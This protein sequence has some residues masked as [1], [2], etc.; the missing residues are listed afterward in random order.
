MQNKNYVY[1][2]D[3]GAVG[4]GVHDDWE[5]IR[6]AHN[7]ANERRTEGYSVKAKAGAT[8]LIRDITKPTFIMTD[9]DWTGAKFI[10]DDTDLVKDDLRRGRIF[11][12]APEEPRRA[13]TEEEI[14]E[15][16]PESKIDKNNFTSVKW[17]YGFPALLF[18]Y[19]EKHKNYRRMGRDGLPTGGGSQL[20]LISVDKD[21]NV[22]DTTPL[23]CDYEEITALHIIRCDDMPITLHGGRFT[24]IK[25]DTVFTAGIGTYLER[26]I[27]SKRSNITY[28]GVEHY[29]RENPDDG[30]KYPA[31]SGFIFLE[32]SNNV[33]LIG[34]TL[35]GHRKYFDG[36]YDFQCYRANDILLYKC[37]QSNF[38]L[39]DGKTP[40][41]H[42]NLYWGIMG[43]SYCKNITFDSCTMSRYDAHAGIYNGK[44]TNCTMNGI[45]IIGGGDFL[46]ENSKLVLSRNILIDL[47]TDYGSTWRGNITIRNCEVVNFKP[48]STHVF[49]AHW[50]NWPFGYECH[51]PN[52]LIDGLKF[53]TV[54]GEIR[55][56]R[57]S[58]KNNGIDSIDDTISEKTLRDGTEN[59]N[60]YIP[61]DSIVIKNSD[62][63]Y[64]LPK[65]SYFDKTKTE[66]VRRT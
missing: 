59:K 66:G 36:T 37:V 40:S 30:N 12:V 45:E 58:A 42:N 33:K 39:E 49:S 22:S 8:Y 1:Y 15:I 56:Y 16:F 17:K 61:A 21:G 44:I 54:E 34:C 19:N 4:D 27:F 13:L 29:V 65:T 64:T 18:I 35:T 43:S 14:K 25:N 47:R 41:M 55:I 11:H 10:I 26:G 53:D 5:A 31:S 9:V 51:M 32:D 23:L 48:D 46:I 3:F 52:L 20:E 2:E 28:L 60:P 6:D 24:T 57:L 38:Y 62:Y 50:A 63:D 7:Y